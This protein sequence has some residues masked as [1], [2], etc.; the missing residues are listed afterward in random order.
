M[1]VLHLPFFM[2]R[3]W[4][5][6]ALALLSSPSCASS[7]DA[8]DGTDGSHTG[9]CATIFNTAQGVVVSNCNRPTVSMRDVRVD[10]TGKLASYAF[11]VICGTQAARGTWDPTAGLQCIEGAEPTCGDDGGCGVMSTT[12][13]RLQ[14]NCEQMGACGYSNGPCVYTDD[15]CASSQVSCGLYG[16]CHLGPDGTCIVTSDADC[17]MP[18]A[19]CASCP[20]HGA[21]ASAGN[22]HLVNGKCAAQSDGD[23]RGSS[24]C[25]F[26]GLCSLVDGA[27]AAATDA[28]CISAEVCT[29]S[30]QCKASMGVCVASL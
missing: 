18:F 2:R 10:S 30:A 19:S 25:S 23:C 17:Q 20:F 22:C 4:C 3:R 21:C 11:I 8:F 13:C 5:V 9:F 16:Q 29:Q 1:L 27:C 7:S 26:A 14:P 15:G 12:D 6:V 28:D 24:Q